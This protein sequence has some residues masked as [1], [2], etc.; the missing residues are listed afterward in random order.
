M[1]DSTPHG[2]HLPELGL[3]WLPPAHM[4]VSEVP[5]VG[6]GS[7]YAV[8]ELLKV[9]KDLKAQKEQCLFLKKS[10][11]DRKRAGERLF[12]KNRRGKCYRRRIQESVQTCASKR[13][14]NSG[15]NVPFQIRA[16]VVRGAVA[17]HG[18][19]IGSFGA[20]ALIVGQSAF[21]W[22]YGVPDFT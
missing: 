19:W 9:G 22:K 15:S 21:Q 8:L 1:P 11:P 18:A 7:W 6:Y 16:V 4:K 13:L 20:V 3:Q 10:N 5:G 17:A 2:I 14:A 12:E